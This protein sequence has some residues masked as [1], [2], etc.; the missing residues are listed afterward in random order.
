[1]TEIDDTVSEYVAKAKASVDLYAELAK[2]AGARVAGTDPQPTQSWMDDA[3]AFWSNAGQDAV[4][5]LTMQ[6]RLA[7]AATKKTPTT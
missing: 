4:N 5:L 6:Q 7:S 3:I 2:R 1:M